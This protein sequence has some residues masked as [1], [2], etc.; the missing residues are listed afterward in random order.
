MF[1]I[2]ISENGDV[3]LSGRLDAM[4][5]DRFREVMDG[6]ES[7][8]KVDFEKLEYISSAGLGLLLSVQKRLRGRGDGLKLVGFNDHIH[9][10]FRLAGFDQVFDIG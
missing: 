10:V 2:R 9:E 6:I 1:E 8:C 4:Q 7:S 5:A 3:F